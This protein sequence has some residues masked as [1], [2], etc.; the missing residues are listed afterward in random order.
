M[1]DGLLTVLVLD[2]SID[3]V[4]ENHSQVLKKHNLMTLH[5]GIQHSITAKEETTLL[6]TNEASHIPEED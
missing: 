5:P 4:L 3:F 1:V 2:G 6:I